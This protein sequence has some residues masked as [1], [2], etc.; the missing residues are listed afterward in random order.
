[1]LLRVRERLQSTPHMRGATPSTHLKRRWIMNFNPRPTCVGRRV[2]EGKA[3]GWDDTSIHAPHA[4]GDNTEAV[5]DTQGNVLQSTPHMRGATEKQ[6]QNAQRKPTS[7]HAP[8]AWGDEIDIE[9]TKN[10]LTSIHA[11]HAWGDNRELRLVLYVSNFNP[12]PTCVGRPIP[13]TTVPPA[14]RLQST[15]HMRGATAL[16]I[17]ERKFSWTLQSTPHMRGATVK[18]GGCNACCLTSIHAPHAWGDDGA[19]LWQ[20]LP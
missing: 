19:G 12:R 2:V 16:L 6:G 9:A 4:W 14:S 5:T 20:C 13:G 18:V 17:W 7:I 11:P 1:M 15:P 3:F 8:H 10:W